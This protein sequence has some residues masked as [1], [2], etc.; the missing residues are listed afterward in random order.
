MSR[1][2]L[3]KPEALPILNTDAER[4]AVLAERLTP[5][6]LRSRLQAPPIWSPETT[7]ESR[8]ALLRQQHVV[9]AP[10]PAAVLVPVVQRDNELT[11]LLTQRTAHLHDHAGQIS[12]P[13]GRSEPEDGSPIATALR[14]TQEEIGLAAQHIEI[15]GHLP[16]YFTVT[17]Y[18]VT[19]VVALISPPFDL[20]PDSFEVAEIFEVPLHFL[21][22]PANHQRRVYQWD[23]GERQFY[24]MPYPKTSPH[25]GE[26]FIWGATAGMLRNLYHLLAA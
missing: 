19:P 15:L 17:N 2:L 20:Q 21:M 8:M 7:D 18:R 12:F 14:E 10:T 23:G 4:P 26:Y 9:K 6:F 5:D 24:A 16:D 22:N 1:P 3:T 25:A 11:L 13:G